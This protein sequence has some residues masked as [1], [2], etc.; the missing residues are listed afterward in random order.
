MQNKANL[1]RV[2]MRANC[3]RGKGLGR[4][5]AGLGGAKTKPICRTGET[6]AGDLVG[7]SK[8]HSQGRDCFPRFRGG[9]LAGLLAMTDMRAVARPGAPVCAVSHGE[10]GRSPYQ[11]ASRASLSP[12]R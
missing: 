5:T 9:R 7:R 11:E 4:E 1:Q 10:R 8:P 3:W 6:M 12:K 2:K